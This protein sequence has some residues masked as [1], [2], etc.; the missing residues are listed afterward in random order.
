M[1]TQ[2]NQDLNAAL[3]DVRRA[4]RLL[5]D[6]QKRQF[7]LLSYIRDK[8]DAVAYHQDYVFTRQGDLRGLENQADAGLRFLPFLDISAIWLRH[9]N[10]EN[11]SHKHLPGDL[12]FG[13]WVRSDTGF[14]KYQ[15]VYTEKSAELSQ[16]VLVLSVVICDEPNDLPGNWFNK[17]WNPLPYPKDG[18]VGESK[19]VPG[20]RV[21]S[22]SIDLAE[23]ADQLS[24]DAA[25]EKWRKKA[26]IVLKVSQI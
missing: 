13:A 1:E 15:G 10:Q 20:Y 18:E 12:M 7:D 11:F 14:D 6:Y 26:A 4:Y 19:S 5:A 25:I 3:L 16:S 22:N 2:M 8:L 9:Q 17:V 23:L 21:Y 24:V